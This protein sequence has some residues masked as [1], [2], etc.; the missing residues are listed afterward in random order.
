[1]EPMKLSPPLDS[2][3]AGNICIIVFGQ[4]SRFTD[5]NLNIDSLTIVKLDFEV[6][7]ASES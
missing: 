3:S 6:A 1:M 7:G 5:S 4:N 2:S